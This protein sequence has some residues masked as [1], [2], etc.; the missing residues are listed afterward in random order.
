MTFDLVLLGLAIA[1]EPLPLIGYLVLLSS[2]RGALMGLGFLTGWVLTL[3]GIVVLTLTLTA[4]HPPAKGSTPSTTML[5]VKIVLGIALLEL[6]RRRRRRRDLPPGTPSWMARM[7]DPR[8]WAAVMLGFL[9]LPWPLAAAG[10]A[11]V[12][13]V[14]PS[15][16]SSVAAL[17]VFCLLSSSSYLTVQ[18]YVARSPAAAGARLTAIRIWLITQQNTIVVVASS[19]VGLWL[20]ADSTYLLLAQ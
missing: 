6:A 10:A 5:I 14:D 16:A 18:A 9:L 4:G 20:V 12:T 17:V 11:T 2:P 3:V 1:I 7:E 19:V 13:T 15:Q 8:V